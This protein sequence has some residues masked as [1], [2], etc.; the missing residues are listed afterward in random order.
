M[1][2]SPSLEKLSLDLFRT[3][4]CFAQVGRVEDVADQLGMTQ[5]AVSLQLK[6]LE[7]EVGQPLFQMVGRRKLLTEFAQ[8]LFQTLAP[9]LIDVQSRL[10]EASISLNQLTDQMIRIAGPTESLLSFAQKKLAGKKSA[11]T[12]IDEAGAL[13]MLRD[14]E[15]D[16]A[17]LSEDP[18]MKGF[19]ASLFTESGFKLVI[20]RSLLRAHKMNMVDLIQKPQSL[21]K[22][23]YAYAES[24]I[25][26]VDK[27]GEYVDDSAVLSG[28]SL[29]TVMTSSSIELLLKMMELN[30][31]W[32]ILSSAVSVSADFE[33]HLLQSS[34]F[35]SKELWMVYPSYLQA[36][37]K[38]ENIV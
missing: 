14:G 2:M 11:L 12:S 5:A 28:K 4:V 29:D 16:L 21:A 22:L 32:S 6:K 23:P 8:S 15:C 33:E 3:F 20:H 1:Q 26:T 38:L 34:L 18:K 9:P 25:V 37:R 31:S 35:P 30:P 19:S 27:V 36:S 7:A 10:K 24:T 17:L 13:S